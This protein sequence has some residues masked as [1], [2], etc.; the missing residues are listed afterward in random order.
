MKKKLPWGLENKVNIWTICTYSLLP[1]S[2]M[3]TNIHW[4]SSKNVFFEVDSVRW[5]PISRRVAIKFLKEVSRGPW[6]V[7]FLDFHHGLNFA[8][9]SSYLL[10]LRVACNSLSASYDYFICTYSLRTRY[11]SGSNCAH[12]LISLQGYTQE[13]LYCTS[14]R[15]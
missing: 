4:R 14:T 8:F 3:K 6:K 7:H 1:K 2:Q 9:Y 15:M 13:S 10:A 5:K 11:T 12:I